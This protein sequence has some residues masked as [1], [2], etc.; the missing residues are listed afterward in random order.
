MCGIL[1]DSHRKTSDEQKA[2]YN[3]HVRT[4]FWII[5]DNYRS[6][7]LAMVLSLCHPLRLLTSLVALV[8]PPDARRR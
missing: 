6:A 1:T 4:A 5:D 2:V 3:R 7:W 8:R